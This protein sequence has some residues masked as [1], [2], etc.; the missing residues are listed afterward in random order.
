MAR[1]LA[2]TRV[3]YGT[4]AAIRSEMRLEL[5]PQELVE[6]RHP[7]LER[8]LVGAGFVQSLIHERPASFSHARADFGVLECGFPIRRLLR[9]HELALKEC[10]VFGVVELDDVGARLG[11]ARNDGADDQRMRIPLNHEV[12]EVGEPDCAVARRIT[13]TI[14]QHLVVPPAIDAAPGTGERVLDSAPL[15]A[16]PLAELPIEIRYVDKVPEARMIRLD[17]VI[18]EIDLD[19]G[20][21]VARVFV[22]LHPVKHESRKIELM[23]KAKRGEIETDVAA[24][25]EQQPVPAGEWRPGK[26]EAGITGKMR[27]AEKLAAQ[28]VRPAMERA[29][30]IPHRATP[31][32]DDRL[33]VA[34]DVRQQ[35]DALIA[36]DQRFGMSEPVERLIIADV[37]HHQLVSDVA[38]TRVEQQPLF[39]FVEPGIEIPVDR[40][41]RG[42]ADYRQRG[43]I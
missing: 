42:S 22:G 10:N 21:P 33:P 5:P 14:A 1:S 20:F 36:V 12:G 37:G 7:V 23:R 8:R 31:F 4:E 13:F 24:P 25:R 26:V 35:L 38:R 9:F 40:K 11:A 43:K 29:D 34:A 32:E 41:L 15:H 18:L 30:D 28:V 6:M 17:V 19:E 27:C 2:L 16:V 39:E 3:W